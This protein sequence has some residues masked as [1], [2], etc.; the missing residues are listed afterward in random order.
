[1]LV[2]KTMDALIAL[3]FCDTSILVFSYALIFGVPFL[4]IPS[5]GVVG[6]PVPSRLD[7]W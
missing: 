7:S 4:G 2:G 6:A 5:L 3:I 1:M